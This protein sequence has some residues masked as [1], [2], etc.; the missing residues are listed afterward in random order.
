MIH[1]I[2]NNERTTSISVIAKRIFL[3]RSEIMMKRKNRTVGILVSIF[4]SKKGELSPLVKS[5]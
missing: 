3:A 4:S 1:A 2:K 5:S